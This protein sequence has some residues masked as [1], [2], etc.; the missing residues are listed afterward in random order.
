MGQSMLDSMHRPMIETDGNRS[1]VITGKCAIVLYSKTEMRIQC[2]RLT[3]CVCGTELELQ[4]LDE[5]EIC[6]C[7]LIMEISFLTGEG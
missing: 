2:G 4:C 5:S 1:V 6:I 3:V 7:G